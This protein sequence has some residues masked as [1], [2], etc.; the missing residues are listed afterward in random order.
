MDVVFT[1]G[2]STH[3]LE[4]FLGLLRRHGVATL[5]DVRRHPG[6]RRLPWFAAE[7]LR[8]AWP[9]YVH[10]PELGGRRSR[11]R[12]SP[13]TGWQV[14][15]FA[16]YADHMAGGEFERG[17]ARLLG[18]PAPVAIMCAEGNWWQCHRRL[19]ADALVARDH[20]V[21]HIARDGSV[22]E[23]ELTPFAVVEPGDPPRLRYPPPQLELERDG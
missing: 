19:I 8:E 4:D 17:V 22:T 7:S 12:D 1:V 20:R 3:P 18:L 21:L 9:G 2:H 5:A 15:A 13:N 10:L 14:A 16:A 6:S 11:R 23:H